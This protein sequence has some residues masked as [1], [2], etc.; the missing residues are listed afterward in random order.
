MLLFA[1][2]GRMPPQQRAKFVKLAALWGGGGILLMLIL[3]GKLHPLFAA[4][5]AAF[6]WIQRAIMMRSAYQMFNSW[7]GPAQSARPGESSDV[8]TKY[9]EMTLDHDSGSI[10]GV[11]I[12]GERRGKTLDELTIKEI[13]E[14]M[15]LYQARDKQSVSLLQAYLDKMRPDEWEDYAQTHASQDEPTSGGESMTH[16]EALE[17]L[18]LEEGATREQIIQAHRV[19]M[20]RNHPDRGGSDWL[21]ARI[22]QAKD[23]LLSK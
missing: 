3:T 5:G 20:Q 17:I 16:S 22:N 1:K 14:L 9:L 10:S 21:A 18:G 23:L 15:S 13:A 4:L 2:L 12:K 11:V 8:R 6:P 7:A 19:L